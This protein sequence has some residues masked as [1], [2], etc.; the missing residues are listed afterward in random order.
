[1][2]NNTDCTNQWIELIQDAHHEEFG[3]NLCGGNSKSFLIPQN[4]LTVLSSKDHHGIIRYTPSELVITARSG[5]SLTEIN[6]L[7]KKHNQCLDFTA[8]CY[9]PDTTIGGVIASGIA[10]YT[11]P[12]RG[13]VRDHLLG[14]SMIN[15]QAEAM[16]FGGEV[17]KNVAGYDVSRLNCG[18]YGALGMITDVS[19]KVMPIDKKSQS[20]AYE[21]DS[22]TAL[23]LMTKWYRS[24][25]P[26]KGACY[27]QGH[28]YYQLS[29]QISAVNEFQK[30]SP[31]RLIDD[32]LWLTIN[33]HQHDFFCHDHKEPNQR[34][35]RINLPRNCAEF[36]VNQ[37]SQDILIEWGGQQCWLWTKE[38]A[39]EL[40]ARLPQGAHCC[41]YYGE[42]TEQQRFT[43]LSSVAAKVH[44]NIKKAFDP[45]HIFN[46]HLN[47]KWSAS[48]LS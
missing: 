4:Q 32:T 40:R 6:T 14:L 39:S 20:L 24:P 9:S 7:L 45:K 11:A 29:G 33:N 42:D 1:M 47:Q 18:A 13:N 19:L 43:P 16:R 41:L 22:D 3:L 10:G 46:P 31:G 35:W 2:T 25:I 26:V 28:L 30:N 36:L 38:T 48:P 23:A 17:I 34:L 27:H 8:P 21:C 37:S 5:T 12:W 44:L 15:G